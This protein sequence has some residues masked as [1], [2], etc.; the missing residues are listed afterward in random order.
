[1]KNRRHVQFGTESQ[2][3]PSTTFWMNSWLLSQ[4]L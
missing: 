3:T 2:N 4:Q 1:M